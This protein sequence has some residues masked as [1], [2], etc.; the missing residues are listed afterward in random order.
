MLDLEHPGLRRMVTL[1]GPV[2][3][4]AGVSQVATVVNRM[5]ASNLAT[6][7]IAALNYATRLMRLVPGVVGVSIVTLMYP[8]LARLAAA[9]DWSR[10][11]KAFS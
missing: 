5:L 2:L 10:Y 6:G 3:L 1:T 4:S 7:S 11:A 9:R 8:T